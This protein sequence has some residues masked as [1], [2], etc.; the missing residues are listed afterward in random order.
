MFKACQYATN[1][2]KVATSLK[3][4][5]VKNAQANL[6]KTITWTKRK[7]EKGEAKRRHVLIVGC[8]IKN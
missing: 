5:N 8:D 4:V 6:Q 7:R 2:D 3:H 1:D